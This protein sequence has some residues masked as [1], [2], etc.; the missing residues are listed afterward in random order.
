MT[1]L[2]E[3]LSIPDNEERKQKLITYATSLRINA[4][5]LRGAN[6]EID[7][8][9]LS[10]LIY[11]AEKRKKNLNFQ[12]IGFIFMGMVILGVMIVLIGFLS[13]LMGAMMGP[14]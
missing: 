13:R 6:G 11:D 7:E 14:K 2:E 10:V 12:N 5:L 9:K 3:I 1:P 8:A 4:G